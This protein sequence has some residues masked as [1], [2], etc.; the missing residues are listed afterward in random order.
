MQ[1]LWA[2]WRMEFIEGGAPAGCIFCAL[3]QET[4]DEADRRNLIVARTPLSFA[5]LNRFP[6]NS[7]HL[8]VIPLRH[9]AEFTS[10]T[11]EESRDLN[12]LLQRSIS[13]LSEAYRPD[14]FNIGMNL[15]RSAGAGIADHL[16]YHAVPRWAGDTNFMPVL[17]ATKVLV[18][19]LQKSYDKLHAIFQRQSA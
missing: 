17:G 16:H 14:G 6:Y 12:K 19:H 11:E 2:P 15:G 5:I 9:T 7:G 8:M 13:A 18:E 10:L 1:P 3:P 4:G